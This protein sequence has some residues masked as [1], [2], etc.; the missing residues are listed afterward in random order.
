M[1]TLK[2]FKNTFMTF[3]IL[4][5]ILGVVI[6]IWPEISARIICNV[7]GILTLAFGA[8]KVI[9]YFSKDTSNMTFGFDLAQGILYIILGIFVLSSP[10]VVISI[11]PFILG[12]VIVID[13]IIRM[14]LAVDLKRAQYTKWST[15]LILAIITGIFGAILLFNPFAGGMALT[16]YM[17]ISLVV[18]GVV[19]LWG[20][21][22]VTKALK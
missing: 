4:Y 10:N 5:I 14:Q 7:L 12:L 9:S 19:N 20:L 18:D 13:S 15:S 17:G 22:Y 3:S 1:G 16:I 8:V 21:I 2:K 6:I 11:L